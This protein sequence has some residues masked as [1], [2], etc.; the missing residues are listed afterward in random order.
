MLAFVSNLG[1]LLA[2]ENKSH[3]HHLRSFTVGNQGIVLP[4]YEVSL[5]SSVP[6]LASHRTMKGDVICFD[7]LIEIFMLDVG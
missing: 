4:L 2:N 5:I 7:L 3:L 1:K 6:T